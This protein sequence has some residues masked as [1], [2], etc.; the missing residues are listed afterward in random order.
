[1]QLSNWFFVVNDNSSPF[2]W[3]LRQFQ[4]ESTESVVVTRQA[5]KEA[6]SDYV[7]NHTRYM[8]GGYNNR[9]STDLL[10]DLLVV[11]DIDSQ[12]TIVIDVT[13]L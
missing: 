7:S 12:Q 2:P 11:T 10:G 13:N 8:F 1:M 9:I 4:Y 3:A 5:T 6:M